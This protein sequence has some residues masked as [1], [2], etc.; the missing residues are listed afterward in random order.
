MTLDDV[1][2]CA[3]RRPRQLFWFARHW[4]AE[5]ADRLWQLWHH[6]NA[7]R[8]WDGF[9]HDWPVWERMLPMYIGG[10]D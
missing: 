9:A 4:G 6:R 7:L 8:L 2:K 3:W 1:V 5:H 10:H